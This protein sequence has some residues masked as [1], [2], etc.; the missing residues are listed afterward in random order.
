MTSWGVDLLESLQQGNNWLEKKTTFYCVDESCKT[1][2]NWTLL[3]CPSQTTWVSVR[4]CRR[5]KDL[6]ME[7]TNFLSPAFLKEVLRNF[8]NHQNLIKLNS[9]SAY[10]IINLCSL[11]FNYIGRFFYYHCSRKEVSGLYRQNCQS[12]LG[13]TFNSE[14]FK[15]MS[16]FR[17]EGKFQ[18]DLN[19]A[20]GLKPIILIE[21]SAILQFKKLSMTKLEGVDREIGAAT[22]MKPEM[23]PF[24]I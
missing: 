20:K 14:V 13:K 23:S 3:D 12:R 17:F 21:T 7:G 16:H 9:F 22:A 19:F 11:H 10:R 15:S 4:L 8:Y 18:W 6:S 24:H 5:S 2:S 1:V